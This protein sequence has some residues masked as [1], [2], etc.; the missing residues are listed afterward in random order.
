MKPEILTENRDRRISLTLPLYR[1]H[2]LIALIGRT[3]DEGS[4]HTPVLM[5]LDETRDILDLLQKF[6]ISA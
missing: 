6:Y 3:I 5:N 1:V 4:Y 2:N